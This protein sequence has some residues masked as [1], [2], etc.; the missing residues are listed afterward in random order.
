MTVTSYIKKYGE[1]VT[2]GETSTKAIIYPVEYK[3]KMYIMGTETQAGTAEASIYVMIA[4]PNINLKQ[5]KSDTAIMSK[6]GDYL[7]YHGENFYLGGKCIY[8]YAYLKRRIP[9]ELQDQ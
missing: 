1:D 6:N 9:D 5:L 2:V 8:S 3:S 7:L 4:P